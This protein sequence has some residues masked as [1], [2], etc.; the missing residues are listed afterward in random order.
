MG[1]I[2]FTI[3]AIRPSAS[4]P[5]LLMNHLPFFCVQVASANP[6]AESN[7]HDRMDFVDASQPM[8]CKP[9]VSM[10]IADFNRKGSD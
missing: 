4:T 7:V 10:W 3:V 2:T 9:D 8:T 1:F 5:L 6:P